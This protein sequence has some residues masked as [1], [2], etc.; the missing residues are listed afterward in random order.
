MLVQWHEQHD[1]FTFCKADPTE[2][3]IKITEE[4]LRNNLIYLPRRVVG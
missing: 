3:L 1:D 2:K 4:K